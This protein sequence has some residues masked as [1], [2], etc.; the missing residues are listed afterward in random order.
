MIFDK[1]NGFIKFFLV[2]RWVFTIVLILAALL[3]GV[4]TIYSGVGM[5]SF[6]ILFEYGQLVAVMPLMT[7]RFLPWV[8][9]AFKPFFMTHLIF[10]ITDASE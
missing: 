4:L 6:W 3:K 1:E 8:Y 7:S 9:E 5:M 2:Y 10:Q